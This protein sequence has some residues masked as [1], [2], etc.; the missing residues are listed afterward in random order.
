LERLLSLREVQAIPSGVPLPLGASARNNGVNLAVFSRHATGAR[1]DFFHR[2][3]DSAPRR[4]ILLDAVR[5][6]TGDT[7]HVWLKGIRSGQLSPGRRLAGRSAVAPPWESTVI[8][9]LHVRGYT[10]HPDPS[11]S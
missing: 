10:I 4:S 7:W 2:V 8:Y 11:I 9:E 3:D 6:K 1:I 5:K